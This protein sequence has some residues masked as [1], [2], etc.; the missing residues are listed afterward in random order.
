MAN[1]LKL[2]THQLAI[3]DGEWAA[4]ICW[5]RDV[6]ISPSKLY[7]ALSAFADQWR[8]VNYPVQ[9]VWYREIGDTAWKW[10]AV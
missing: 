9:G 3:D 2:P 1:H 6:W 10:M 8:K 5:R 7:Q 4:G